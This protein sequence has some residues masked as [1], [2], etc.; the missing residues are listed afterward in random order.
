MTQKNM[1]MRWG[2]V[3]FLQ[4]SL[5]LKAIEQRC[6]QQARH[7]VYLPAWTVPFSPCVTLGG[8]GIGDEGDC[9]GRGTECAGDEG[10][11]A[12]RGC[13][14]AGDDFDRST[15]GPT[16][17]SKNV[18]FSQAWASSAARAASNHR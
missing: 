9:A 10:D 17:S 7:Q 16:L 12:S 1:N 8:C 2:T 14:C 15:S 4:R 5:L 6:L 11:C 13:D 3:G 18:P